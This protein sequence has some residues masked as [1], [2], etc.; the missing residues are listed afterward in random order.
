M[1]NQEHQE[2]DADAAFDEAARE[3]E[4][5]ELTANSEPQVAPETEQDT[6]DQR[7]AP[8]SE[9]EQSQEEDDLPE[10]LSSAT[11]EVKDH[12]RKLQAEN[13]RLDHMAKSQRGRVG[14]LSKKYQQAQANLEQLKAKQP[15]GDV[16]EVINKISEDYPDIA[17]ALLQIAQANQ[18]HIDGISKPLSD[19]AE[20]NLQDL[21]GQE[22]DAS[23]NYVTQVI[24]DAEQIISSDQF[25]YWLDKQPNGVKA[26]FNSYD[27]N[28]AIYLLSEYKKALAESSA[29]KE[30]QAKRNQQLS[31][32]SLPNGRSAPK[33]N[34][35]IDEDAIFNQ[36]AEE[37][38]KKQFI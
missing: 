19:I 32:L 35:E 29:I 21:A 27:P 24:P 9:P 11:Q 17:Q 28:D 6:S 7:E 12:F 2:F 22:L 14:A 30:R 13:K 36:I 38:K 25:N 5:G 20:A 1:E 33:G 8:P 4:S 34:E 10:W 37:F 18:Q 3:I 31:A 26:L 23:I 16:T 15:Q